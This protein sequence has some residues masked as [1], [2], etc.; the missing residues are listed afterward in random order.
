MCVRG[1]GCPIDV[2]VVFLL[3]AIR[4]L[5][6]G[7]NATSRHPVLVTVRQPVGVVSWAIPYTES[8]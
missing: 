5:V 6:S 4:V 2:K 8:G 1:V 3:Q 7:D